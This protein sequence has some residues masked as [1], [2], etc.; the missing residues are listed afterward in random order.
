MKLSYLYADI[1][2]Y[3]NFSDEVCLGWENIQD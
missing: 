3:N 2:T 1:E